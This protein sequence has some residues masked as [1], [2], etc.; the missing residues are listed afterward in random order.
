[1]K[2][3]PLDSSERS[4]GGIVEFLSDELPNEDIVALPGDLDKVM[5]LRG[6]ISRILFRGN[7]Y[8]YPI[9][10]ID[11]SIW[12]LG[13]IELS[14]I[15]I[16]YLKTKLIRT[17]PVDNLEDFYINRFGRCLYDL[18]FRSYT[19]KVWGVPCRF[20]NA[21]WGTQRVKEISIMNLLGHALRS[22]LPDMLHFSNHKRKKVLVNKFF[23]PKF[24]P[25]QLWEE[26]ERLVIGQG[27][28]IRKNQRVKKITIQ[29]GNVTHVR[30]DNLING[31]N[32]DLPV[33]YL[34]SSMPIKNFI[35]AIGNAPEEVASCAK[36][37][38]YRD[39]LIV[40]VLASSLSRPYHDLKD[41]WI[42]VQ[43]PHVK[44]GRIQIF[45]NWSPYL[46]SKQDQMWLG[47]EYFLSKGDETWRKTDTE[48]S[49]FA[50]GELVSLGFLCPERVVDS[51]VL[52]VEKAYPMYMGSFN[53]F[54]H[55]ESY[56]DS[57]KN[58]YPIGRNGTHRYN[59]QDHAM[60]T[61]IESVDCLL[62]PTLDKRRVWAIN[63]EDEYLEL[64]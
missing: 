13:V 24:G 27:G 52:R 12:N 56:F 34:F 8:H 10:L 32:Y 48:I 59:N 62:D 33:D 26:V 11:W 61:A 64:E 49:A 25:G 51:C 4:K 44:L 53:R 6:R 30:V 1:M 7:F 31:D 17:K 55:L 9:S 39:Y 29:D 41:M 21:D 63:S 19:E 38:E 16:S 40:G 23:Y 47:L 2:I 35:S 58:L 3:L 60:M 36:E 50:I 37:L 42:Y 45:N 15:I 18:F 22:L 54:E 14:K 43:E 57:I 28:E 46:A 20:L 5:L